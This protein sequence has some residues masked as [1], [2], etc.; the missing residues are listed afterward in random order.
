MFVVETADGSGVA[1]TLPREFRANEEF[2]NSSVCTSTNHPPV[3]TSSVDMLRMTRNPESSFKA[4]GCWGSA[5]RQS[6][7][8]KFDRTV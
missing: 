4:S 1:F 2:V 6:L 5:F 3:R 7:G 8:H